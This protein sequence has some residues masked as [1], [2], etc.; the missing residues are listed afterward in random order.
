[1]SIADHRAAMSQLWQRFNAVAVTNGHAW[2]NDA[3]T[4][5]EIAT[6]APTID[7]SVLRIP[8]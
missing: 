4:A 1:M 7:G 8:S 2:S 6:P 3:Y 5:E